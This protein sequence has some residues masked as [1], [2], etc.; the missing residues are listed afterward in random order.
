[1]D[2]GNNMDS[3]FTVKRIELM[4]ESSLKRAIQQNDKTQEMLSQVLGELSFV[5][6]HLAEQKRN[7]TEQ[8]PIFVQ[9]LQQAQQPI[10]QVAQQ[11]AIQAVSIQPQ[12]PFQQN[13]PTVEHIEVSE[14]GV[15]EIPVNNPPS[16]ARGEP[17][18][19]RFG[20][21]TS[22]DVPIMK[23]FNFGNKR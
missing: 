10:Q 21:Y 5:K 9:P 14:Y 11:P 7:M 8:K 17:L 16:H 19:P 23:F 22:N 12:A 1:M 4:I 13:S 6:Q 2:S 15:V 3:A 20:D 18:K